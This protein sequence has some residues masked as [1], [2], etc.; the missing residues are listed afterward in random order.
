M[1]INK[2]RTYIVAL[3]IAA[4]FTFSGYYVLVIL[5]SNLMG[6]QYS[7]YLTIPVRIVI[8]SLLF[9]CLWLVGK[10]K[11]IDEPVLVA[12][13]L[14]S[15]FYLLRIIVE[16]LQ[17]TTSF[18]SNESF[19]LY[20]LGFGF[21]PFCFIFLKRAYY[22]DQ[23]VIKYAVIASGVIF[24]VL[25]IFFYKEYIGTIGR[26]S[27]AISREDNWITPLALSDS[28]ALTMGVALAMLATANN[29]LGVKLFLVAVVLLSCVPFFLGASRGS[30]LALIAP[31]LLYVFANK[32]KA[33]SFY[34]IILLVVFLVLLIVL[35]EYFGSSVIDRFLSIEKDM[36]RGSS[37]ASRTVIWK[38]SLSHFAD[39]PIFGYSL[40]VPETRHHSH[41]IFIEVLLSTGI[42]GF[43]PFCFLYAKG[44]KGAVDIIRYDA[45]A[46]WIVV[47]FV[48]SLV[49][50]FFHGTVYSGTWF[51]FSLALVLSTSSKYKHPM[52][53]EK[54]QQ[55]QQQ[56]LVNP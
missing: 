17:G 23:K 3:F 41:N 16:I 29:K 33:H 26:I 51:W 25:A 32:N 6:T 37:S 28:S 38:Y 46:S 34:T 35:S 24:S 47:V 44:L 2:H 42:L 10:R 21:F 53:S 54:A 49:I 55:V 48:Q 45:T 18:M 1:V 9:A 22:L 39:H 50:T 36:E 7:R 31:F 15:F 27:L 20:F 40:W 13:L 11:N 14:F 30:V 4:F 19:L 52:Q 56:M 43:I 8:V 12:F 5:S